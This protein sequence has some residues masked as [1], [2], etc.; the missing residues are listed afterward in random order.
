MI[1]DAT[2]RNGSQEAARLQAVVDAGLRPA[3]NQVQVDPEHLQCGQ[4]QAH[5]RHLLSTAA[6]SPLGGAGDFLSHPAI[7]SVAE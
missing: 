6:Y 4:L 7:A 1:F 5:A 3:L 2:R